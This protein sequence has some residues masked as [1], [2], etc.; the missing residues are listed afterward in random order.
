LFLFSFSQGI[1]T[2]LWLRCIGDTTFCQVSF[3]DCSPGDSLSCLNWSFLES[4]FSPQ[5]LEAEVFCSE[6]F[7]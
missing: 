3:K 7:L 4:S 5:N 6:W 2:Y 1:Q